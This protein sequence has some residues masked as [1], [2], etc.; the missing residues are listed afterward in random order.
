MTKLNPT[1]SALV[2]STYL[3]WYRCQVAF[4]DIAVDGGGNTY[5]TGL[6]PQTTFPLTPDAFQTT[7]LCAC[8]RDEVQPY[9]IG[10]GLLHLSGR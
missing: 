3:W 7:C 8:L 9:R 1:G 2:Y 5:V 10:F 6:T 4:L